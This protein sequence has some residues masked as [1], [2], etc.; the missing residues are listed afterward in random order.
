[1]RVHTDERAAESAQGLGAR[2][3]TVGEH[4]TF[5]RTE[6]VPDAKEGQ[7]LIAHE[8]THVVQQGRAPSKT[9]AHSSFAYSSRAPRITRATHPL[10]QRKDDA[11]TV[12]KPGS[13]V[14]PTGVP[15]LGPLDPFK[16]L[17]DRG[18]SWERVYTALAAEAAAAK[19]PNP[20]HKELTYHYVYAEGEPFL[21]TKDKMTQA[22]GYG[23]KHLNI[24]THFPAVT[25]AMA[26]LKNELAAQGGG[27]PQ[28]RSEDLVAT[29]PV[30]AEGSLRVDDDKPSLGGFTCYLFGVLEARQQPNDS[31]ISYEFK[32]SMVW[33]DI[34][35]FD[36]MRPAEPGEEGKAQPAWRSKKGEE[37]TRDAA[38][39]LPGTPF[40]VVSVFLPISQKNTDPF[41]EW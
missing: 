31:T 11:Q 22:I 35:D 20:L 10:V 30:F 19:Y 4:I 24:F 9:A 34:W 14:V 26:T 29:A 38:N 15:A 3:Y 39:Y 13:P 21:L 1:M 18:P 2:A 23:S 8:L 25:A 28:P 16:E 41:P 7:R 27:A 12:P 36:P 5:G 37:A 33:V 6:Y 17:D 40:R 32:G